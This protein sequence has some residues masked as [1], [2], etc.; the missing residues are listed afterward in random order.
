MGW[1]LG[2]KIFCGQF[3]QDVWENDPWHVW[4]EYRGMKNCSTC[5]AHINGASI[6]LDFTWQMLWKVTI[7]N[8]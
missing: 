6:Q 4:I 1:R 3:N 5:H 7:D 2:C 8:L